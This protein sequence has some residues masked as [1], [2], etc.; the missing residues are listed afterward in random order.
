[1]GLYTER[2]K[3]VKSTLNKYFE[4]KPELIELIGEP[5]YYRL[6][7]GLGMQQKK[8]EQ[9]EKYIINKQL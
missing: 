4:I 7:N 1:M 6:K 9:V 2:N 5:A 3:V 8:L